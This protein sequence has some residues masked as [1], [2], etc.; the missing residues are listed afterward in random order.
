MKPAGQYNQV[1]TR[2]ERVSPGRFHSLA[3]RDSRRLMGFRGRLLFALRGRLSTNAVCAVDRH[4][5]H[6]FVDSPND[7]PHWLAITGEAAFL[8]PAGACG[9]KARLPSVGMQYAGAAAPTFH[10]GHHSRERPAPPFAFN[11]S[12][13]GPLK[14]TTGFH[15]DSCR[16]RCQGCSGNRNERPA[17]GQGAAGRNSRERPAICSHNQRRRGSAWMMSAPGGRLLPSPGGVHGPL[18]CHDLPAPVVSGVGVR[19]TM[20]R[21]AGL[22]IG[23]TWGIRPAGC[24][25]LP[26]TSTRVSVRR[27]S[28]LRPKDGKARIAQY[29]SQQV[30]WGQLVADPRRVNGP[31][32]NARE[33]YRQR[34]PACRIGP[35]DWVSARILRARFF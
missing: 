2:R 27:L 15:L 11:A 14:P 5:A 4:P 25:V 22:G 8:Y 26:H 24:L 16:Q 33:Q 30:A 35:A 31:P 23:P 28:R 7:R 3:V 9:R 10:C 32:G 13:P 17:S 18:L 6:R 29:R 1:S 20:R 34:L 19:L 21:G 12:R